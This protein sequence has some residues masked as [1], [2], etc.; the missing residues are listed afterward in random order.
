MFVPDGGASFEWSETNHKTRPTGFMGV[1]C[2]P[3]Q[4]AKSG[5]WAQILTASD[6]ANDVYL[7]HININNAAISTVARDIIMDVGVDEAGGTSYTLKIA[8]LIG[9]CAGT[10]NGSGGINYIF[11]LYIKAGS[12]VACKASVNASNLGGFRIWAKIYGRPRNLAAIRRGCRVETL[13]IVAA[14]SRGTLVTP[15]TT[16]E[17]AWTLIGTTT[18]DGWWIQAGMGVNDATM[19]SVCYL[20]DVAIGSNGEVPLITNQ[21][22]ISNS[23]ET[24]SSALYI[25][26]EKFIPAGS[27]IYARLWCEGTADANTS[28]AVYIL[29]G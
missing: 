19:A 11:P 29:G 14:S 5:S 24:H 23:V 2:T 21:L 12:T 9:S 17:G 10:N 15:G 16:N 25:P 6:V 27:P 7:I 20:L 18:Q 4:N 8:D 22:W 3:A 26:C 28:V 13:G 1:V